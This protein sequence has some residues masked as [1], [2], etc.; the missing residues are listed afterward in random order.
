[1][2]AFKP[3]VKSQSKLRCAI[4]ALSGAGKTMT[5][6]RIATGIAKAIG[7]TIAVIDSEHGSASKYADRF[8]F[9]AT[10]PFDF[11]IPTYIDLI[12]QAGKAG[13]GVLV[14][15]GLTQTWQELCAHV[16]R[17]AQTKFRGNSWSAWSEGT[18]LQRSLVEA[19]LSYPGHVIATMRVDTE[20]AQEDVGGR[21]KPVKVGLK[22]SQGKGIEYEFDMLITLSPDHIATVEKDRTSKFQD[23]LITKPGEEFGEELI[24]WLN[25]GEVPTPAVKPTPT[26]TSEPENDPATRDNEASRKFAVGK[27]DLVIRAHKMTPEMVEAF[28]ASATAGRPLDSLSTSEADLILPRL[29]ALGRLC[30]VVVEHKITTSQVEK[31]VKKLGHTH[32]AELSAEEADRV[33][34]GIRKMKTKQTVAA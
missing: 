16:D 1:M 12:H 31:T 28:C 32:V 18:P 3:A 10:E 2:S 26:T 5:A 9:D 4:A 17:I 14:I 24:A 23:R 30:S 7:T 34:D 21:K 27:L 20:W 19:I 22:P 29:E 11:S 25:S 13:Y 33:S 6:L 15:D 8:K